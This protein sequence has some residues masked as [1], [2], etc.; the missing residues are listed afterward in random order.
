LKSKRENEFIRVDQM[1]QLINYIFSDE[2][3]ETY[4]K[5]FNCYGLIITGDFNAEPDSTTINLIEQIDFMNKFEMINVYHDSQY[6]TY[7][8]KNELYR[9]TI[10]YIFITHKLELL[11]KKKL[12][13]ESKLL[14]DG[15]PN[16]NIPSDHLFL[17]AKIGFM[18]S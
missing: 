3:Y 14:P 7:K 15:L 5:K 2:F 12:P 8:F 4:K 18:D 13:I 10:D 6:T 16:R 1:K 11:W 9:R 17:R